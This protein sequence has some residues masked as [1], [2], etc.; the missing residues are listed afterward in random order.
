MRGI[1]L[2][3]E[4]KEDKDTTKTRLEIALHCA[5]SNN[6]YVKVSLKIK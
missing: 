5:L 2:E 3:I 4:I 1:I 6:I